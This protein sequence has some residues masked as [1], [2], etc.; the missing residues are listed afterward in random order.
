MA[1][2]G[3]GPSQGASGAGS[4]RS[5]RTGVVGGS[6]YAG[7]E[8][9]RLLAAHPHLEAAWVTGDSNAGKAVAD[10]YPSLGRAYP[11]LRFEAFEPGRVDE[12]DV[13]W[14]ALPHGESQRVVPKIIDQVAHIVDLAADFR[15]PLDDYTHWYGGVHEA[16]TLIDRFTFGLPELHHDELLTATHIAAP[17][18]NATVAILTLA[19]LVA[20]GL[21]EPQGIVVNGMAG[22]SGAGRALKASSLFGEANENVNAYG[23]VAHRHTAEME[24][25][26][27]ALGPEPVS[28]LFNPHLVPMTRGILTTCTARTA[29]AGLTTGAALDAARD[30]YADAPFVAVLDESPRTKAVTGSNEVHLTYRVDPRTGTAIGIGAIDNLVKGTAGQAIQ[31]LNLALGWPE[32]TGLPTIGL[33]P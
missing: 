14:L 11:S 22:V 12:V 21:I 7:A 30:F 27:S 15:L 18:C 1:N 13:V 29:V 3:V 25:E 24:R 16:P 32:T 2:E 5:L 20:A 10:L 33:L 4:G 8:V 6:G 19:P 23:L 28:V 26:L 17:G 31:A 9:L